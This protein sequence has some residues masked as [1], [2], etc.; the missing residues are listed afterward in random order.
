MTTTTEHDV[1]VHGDTNPYTIHAK[2]DDDA[3]SVGD[4]SMEDLHEKMVLAVADEHGNKLSYPGE[5]DA[6]KGKKPDG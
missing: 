1:A 5:D 2:V 4:D 3:A 6:V